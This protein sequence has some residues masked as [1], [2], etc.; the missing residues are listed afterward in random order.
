MKRILLLALQFTFLVFPALSQRNAVI[1]VLDKTKG[2]TGLW[3]YQNPKIFTNGFL[4]REERG[5]KNITSD[6]TYTIIIEALKQPVILSC[7]WL[8]MG[9]KQVIVTPGDS[10]YAVINYGNYG[11]SLFNVTFYGK[12]EMN[13]NSYSDLKLKFNNDLILNKAQSVTSY[14]QYRE[15]LDSV[16]LN[17]T[18]IIDTSIK[19]SALKS[20]LLEEEKVQIFN[21]LNYVNSIWKNKI[22]TE[23]IKK[24]IQIYF[25]GPIKCDNALFFQSRNYT[26]GMIYLSDLL[27]Q[28]ISTLTAQTDT[29]NKYFKGELKDYILSSQFNYTCNFNKKQNTKDINIENWYKMYSGK[30]SD[31]IYND[32][33]DYAYDKY[34]KLGSP[35]PDEIL[36]EKLVNLSDGSIISFKDIID[37]YKGK[38]III[39]NWASWCGPCAH[40]I[41]VGKNNILEL[42]KRNCQFI[43]LSLDRKGDLAKA[44]IKAKE[45]GIFDSAYIV[46]KD[47][48]SCYSKYFRITSIPRFILFDTNGNVK[49]LNLM[50][51]SSV[52]NY[53]SYLE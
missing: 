11:R 41:K 9:K 45:L 5:K 29:I 1:T 24:L 19:K 2:K 47:F 42:E 37:K 52:S 49:K 3:F 26:L 43:Y 16:F 50:F 23:E 40:E 17:H 36:N 51:P 27:I 15:I 13:Y 53:S 6:S 31:K 48:Q 39:D 18:S 8:E 44:K 22:P 32:L 33:L 35:L 38:Q 34:K 12:N 30:M 21:Y 25:P 20:L 46:S 4:D 7:E 10:I 14:E 28:D